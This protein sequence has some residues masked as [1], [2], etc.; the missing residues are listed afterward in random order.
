M[1]PQ[2][3]FP[4]IVIPAFAA[5]IL[6]VLATGWHNGVLAVGSV[7]GLAAYAGVLFTPFGGRMLRKIFG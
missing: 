5:I 4:I 1:I 6:G 7:V 3:F 2:K